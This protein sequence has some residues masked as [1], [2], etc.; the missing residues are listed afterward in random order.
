[1]LVWAQ[2]FAMLRTFIFALVSV[3]AAEACWAEDKIVSKVDGKIVSYFYE[4]C[5]EECQVAT[6]TCT[7]TASL[8]VILSDIETKDAAKAMQE[9]ER[10]IVFKVGPKTFNYSISEMT[11]TEMSGAWWLT[12]YSNNVDQ[13]D[14]APAIATVKTFAARAGRHSVVLPVDDAVQQWAKACK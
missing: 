4:S 13:K 11:F 6:F 3:L 14:L 1:M 2:A 5:P 7:E 9:E 10:Q 8:T 12:G